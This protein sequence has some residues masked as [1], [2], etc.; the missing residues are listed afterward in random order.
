MIASCFDKNIITSKHQA[1][2]LRRV[3]PPGLRKNNARIYPSTV[4]ITRHSTREWTFLRKIPFHE[5]VTNNEKSPLIV[6]ASV[7]LIHVKETLSDERLT[8]R[9]VRGNSNHR[10]LI[11]CSDILPKSHNAR[12]SWGRRLAIL[13]RGTPSMNISNCNNCSPYI[14]LWV[15]QTVVCPRQWAGHDS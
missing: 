10:G 11:S 7:R 1:S 9:C 4:I 5:N 6:V 13:F 3:I 8:L 12:S 2:T 14:Y 15:L